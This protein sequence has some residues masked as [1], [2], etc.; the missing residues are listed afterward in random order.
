MLKKN[1]NNKIK[2]K[3]NNNKI[4]KEKLKNIIKVVLKMTLYKI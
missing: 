1:N 4:I 2:E 3:V